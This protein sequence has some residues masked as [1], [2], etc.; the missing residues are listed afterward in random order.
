MSELEAI[1]I[2]WLRQIKRFIRAR[3]RVVANI[4]QPLLFLS[5]FGLGF[6][7]IRFPGIKLSYLDFLTPGIVTMG[8][9]FSSIFGGISVLWDR[10]FGFLKEVLVAPVKRV[11]IVVG[12]ALGTITTAL[13]Q[14]F[15]ILSIAIL[16]GAHINLTGL[17]PSI[18]VMFLVSLTYVSLGLAIAS[19]I[20]DFHGFQLIMNLIIMPM[21]LLSTAFFPINNIPQN[22]RIVI[23]LDPLTYAVDSLRWFL[24]GIS[25][26]SLHYDFAVTFLTSLS[27]LALSTYLFSK[28]QV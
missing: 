22:L 28:M 14:G 23:Y 25:F 15:I 21:V 5:I 10:Q 3:S 1:Y 4:V 9:V 24:T 16:L 18:L 12:Y 2:M 19:K 27:M 11:S 13:I 6:G 17:F 8:I 26:I 20:E 7:S